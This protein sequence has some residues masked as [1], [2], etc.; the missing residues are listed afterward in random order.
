MQKKKKRRHSVATQFSTQSQKGFKRIQNDDDYF[1]KLDTTKNLS[2]LLELFFA[3]SLE[4]DSLLL[5]RNF[6]SV[7]SLGRQERD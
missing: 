4:M 1:L 6:W 2:L 3:E 7:C 5:T